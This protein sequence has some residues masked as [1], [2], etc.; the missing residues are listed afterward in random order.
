MLSAA[1]KLIRRA[2]DIKAS[3]DWLLETSFTALGHYNPPP[4]EGG[5][6]AVLSNAMSFGVDSVG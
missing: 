5:G 1:P 3:V 2:D 6:G 4:R